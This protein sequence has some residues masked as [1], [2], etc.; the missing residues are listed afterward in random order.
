MLHKMKKNIME[1]R[2]LSC[3]KDI[4]FEK[5][6]PEKEKNIILLFVE[7]LVDN[8]LQWKPVQAERWDE[9]I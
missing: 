5:N 7:W 6:S 3:T 9:F 1:S 4:C 2:H 8:Y